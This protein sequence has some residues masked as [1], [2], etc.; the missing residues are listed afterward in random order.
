MRTR[1][2]RRTDAANGHAKRAKRAKTK[3]N[4][5]ELG[6]L[7]E[8]GVH[9]GLDDAGFTMIELVVSISLM[10]LLLGVLAFVFRQSSEAVGSATEAV[11]TVQRARIFSARFGR[12]LAGAKRSVVETERGTKVRTFLLAPNPE[13]D[14]PRGINPNG[15]D[16]IM[17]KS[18]TRYRG[19]KGTW[20]VRYHYED[21]T[22]QYGAIRR[23]VRYRPDPD[24]DRPP[25]DYY[26]VR[27]GEEG[28]K[29][30]RRF[31]SDDAYIWDMEAP[32][33][34]DP[35]DAATD[36]VGTM[37]PPETVVSHV[38][39]IPGRPVFHAVDPDASL[40]EANLEFRIPASVRVSLN[41]V[42]NRG[43]E[44]FVLPMEFW[45]PIYQ[46]E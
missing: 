33:P 24:P 6:G 30:E 37:Q 5:G 28:D 7:G 1:T 10:V 16:S 4:L 15:G 8:L 21:V 40:L 36:P 35:D 14:P 42:D 25:L 17:F 45:F 18:K 22:R 19:I 44:S 38:K 23:M 20:V 2:Y 9:G 41:F 12:D 26:I 39:R 27:G 43:G 46:G 3:K 29:P 11:N 31:L 32:D 13:L 34:Y